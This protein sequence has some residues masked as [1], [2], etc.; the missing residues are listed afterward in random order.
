[1]SARP[2]P[3]EAAAL[4]PFL[5]PV[6]QVQATPAHPAA[7]W[8]GGA[9]IIVVL[10][11]LGW[12]W[13]GRT[14]IV[15]VAQGQLVP[16][17]QVKPLRSPIEG[18]VA[19]V[20]VHEGQR[21]LAGQPL[22]SLDASAIRA[23]LAGLHRERRLLLARADALQC[24]LACLE[25]A[26][27]GRADACD[28]QD[29][30]VP[31]LV[32]AHWQRLGS[33]RADIA[34]A[35]AA[36]QA[37]MRRARAGLAAEV[38]VLPLVAE[39]ASAMAALGE[40]G[41]GSRLAWLEVEQERR[42]REHAIAAG[43][44]GIAALQATGQALQAR[45]AHLLADTRVD[46]LARL[47]DAIAA[48]A[49]NATQLR[50]ARYR[51]GQHSLVAPAAGRVHRLGVHAAGAVVRPA[52]QVLSIVPD[53]EQLLAEV[54]VRNRDRGFI[55]V[56]QRARL[57]F[58]AFPFTRFGTMEGTVMDIAADAE[59]DPVAGLVF[60]VRVRPAAQALPVAGAPMAL[61]PGMMVSA[62]ILTG[63]R[64]VIEYLLAP[65]LRYRD[66]AGRER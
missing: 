9:I 13:L 61:A 63:Q 7:G 25:A 56:G 52:E 66:E 32:T 4:R 39:R 38:D 57:K 26:G 49:A 60:R 47:D 15:A 44:A 54:A 48:L 45:D 53:A 46:W 21:V 11:G 6:A 55:E 29:A 33:R 35:R 58:A 14:D 22:L 3:E 31:A 23:T 27:A 20:H 51:L 65:L 17:G 42:L 40:R 24:L 12:A 50:L 18:A 64:R 8:L 2:P 28:G 36:N 1:M 37:E 16:A 10:L 62:E 19:A 43:K 30:G 41:H 59:A 34:A 5:A